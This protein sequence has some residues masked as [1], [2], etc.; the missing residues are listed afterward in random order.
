MRREKREKPPATCPAPGSKAGPPKS[1]TPATPTSTRP[2]PAPPAA[3]EN[4]C[5]AAGEQS[6]T[7][8]AAVLLANPLPGKSRDNADRT[9]DRGRRPAP[10]AYPDARTQT[11][12]A[13]ENSRVEAGSLAYRDKCIRAARSQKPVWADEPVVAR[14]MLFAPWLRST[15]TPVAQPVFAN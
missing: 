6:I 3:V 11:M 7:G 9:P 10:K 1:V 12:F 15:L 4:R 8:P 2:A 14:S 13:Q 5:D